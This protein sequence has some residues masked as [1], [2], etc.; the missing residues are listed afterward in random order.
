MKG[1][2]KIRLPVLQRFSAGAVTSPSRPESN[3]WKRLM[4]M[5]SLRSLLAALLPMTLAVPVLVDGHEGSETREVRIYFLDRPVPRRPLKGAVASLTVNKSSS[6]SATY[7]L[8]QVERPDNA[9]VSGWIRELV[10]T[11]YF[12]EFVLND[13]AAPKEPGLLGIVPGAPVH[14]TPGQPLNA[15]DVL[16]RAHAGP[17][18]MKKIPAAMLSGSFRIT[19]SIR[20]DN[21]TLSTEE[22]PSEVSP[23]TEA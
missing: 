4:M 22:I 23:P 10:N 1:H 18:F 14:E 13:D 3:A 2:L 20:L 12:V 8:P 21:Q 5:Y 9:P 6:E 15:A 17:C 11:P 7:L 16:R 19:I